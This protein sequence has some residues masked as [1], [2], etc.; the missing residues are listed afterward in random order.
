MTG[1]LERLT[2]ALA[3]RYTIDS[4]IGRGGMAVVFLAEDLKHHRK[5]AIKVLHPELTVTLAADRFLN[6][7]QIAAGLNH[8]HILMLI[9]SGEVDGLLY[10]V[11]P[12]VPGESLRQRLERE[13]Q[14]SVEE[15]VR[16][17]VEVAD[18][19]EYAHQHGVIHR[20]VKPGNI[21]LSSKHAVITDFG[22][23][24]AITVAQGE[25]V[26]STGLGVGTPLYASPEQATG[27][28]TLDGR[29]DIYSLGCVLYEMLSG[30][31]PLAAATPQAVQA[32]RMSETPAAI[33][34]LRDTVPPL[35]DQVIGKALARLPA[36]RWET[37]EKFGQ[38]IMTATMDATPVARLDLATTPGLTVP[39]SAKRRQTKR[40]ILATA[41]LV[42]VAVSAWVVARQREQASNPT[43][44]PVET[45]LTLEGHFGF[46]HD[47]GFGSFSISPDG[48]WLAYCSEDEEA[49][50]W[51]LWLADLSLPDQPHR[52]LAVGTYCEQVRWT[53]SGERVLVAAEI[54]GVGDYYEVPRDG[55]STTPLLDCPLGVPTWPVASQYAPDESR[56]VHVMGTIQKYVRILP[57]GTCDFAQGDSV[58]VAGDYLHLSPLAWSPVGIVLS[59]RYA[60]GATE[61]WTMG[62]D[63]SGQRELARQGHP[64]FS[65]SWS[66]AGRVLYF[67][68]RMPFG[69]RVMRLDVSSSG[70]AEGDPV[71]LD[72]FDDH[73]ISFF[74]LSRDG[75]RAI[76]SRETNKYRAVRVSADPAKGPNAASVE[77]VGDTL[78]G[79]MIHAVSPDGK[80]LAYTTSTA[81]GNDLFKT[82]LEGGPPQRLTRFG[83]V[84]ECNL[85]SCAAWSPDGEYLAYPGMWRDTLRLWLVTADGRST[86]YVQGV[87][88]NHD[89]AHLTWDGPELF[90]SHPG[91]YEPLSLSEFNI[92]YGQWR[93]AEWRPAPRTVDSAPTEQFRILA[94][95]E[96]VTDSASDWHYMIAFGSPDGTRLV[97][98]AYSPASGGYW[99]VISRADS[100]QTLLTGTGDALRNH[101]IGWTPDSGSL[102]WRTGDDIYFWPLDGGEK[103]LLYHL[104]PRLE[105]CR[106]RSGGER[107]EF[108]CLVDESHVDLFLVENL[109]PHV[110]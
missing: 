74:S 3:D 84:H 31:V 96:S 103:E 35:L 58:P 69:R 28:E 56:V 91:R 86:G 30:E 33:H 60:G 92:E 82:S 57:A 97:A 32:R 108:V 93:G 44:V 41:G 15:S 13:G 99:A 52:P 11:M 106:P 87:I 62:V 63:G 45:R 34:P 14:L 49:D 75:R 68:R 76:V 10:Y 100:T 46:R 107:A 105:S 95:A 64:M 51:R 53:P 80:W 19:L 85:W 70:E 55:G 66:A 77:V 16:I 88:P 65:V 39:V 98:M 1:L 27:A 23:A 4:E 40:W 50:A 72:H 7:I 71:A 25:R 21:L 90:Y 48:Q 24:R 61:L 102:Y 26:T 104:P 8:P 79:P 109:D 43:T 22:I 47:V 17:G 12:Y 38:A 81:E 54:D 89:V 78:S 73:P 36:D 5:V 67:D 9:D 29:T 110:N 20:D 59:K 2:A 37:A 42:A 83:H 18:G 101:P 6:E 94:T